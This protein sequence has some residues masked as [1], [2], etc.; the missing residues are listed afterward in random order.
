D[1]TFLALGDGAWRV[2]TDQTAGD[3]MFYRIV[4]DAASGPVLVQFGE[5]STTGLAGDTIEVPITFA[6][7]FTGTLTYRLDDPAL[8]GG[9]EAITGEITVSNATTA[10]ISVAATDDGNESTRIMTLTV[11][12]G[13]TAGYEP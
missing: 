3:R 4:G 8:A 11:E 10:F 6:Q 9:G 2:E 13:E 12:A 5:A 1:A 7:P